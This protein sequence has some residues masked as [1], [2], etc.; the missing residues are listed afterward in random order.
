MFRAHLRGPSTR[1]PRRLAQDD[2]ATLRPDKP[3]VEAAGLGRVASALDD[4]AAIGKQRQLVGIAPELEHGLIVADAAMGIEFAAHLA[5]IHRA[6][7][8][9][10]LHRVAPTK[11]RDRSAIFSFEI[12]KFTR[13]TDAAIR[14]RLV[15]GDFGALI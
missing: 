12:S 13:A 9:V 8:F 6:M 1:P 14:S 15:G 4:G 10:N 5:E 11:Q 7:R 3:R 2:I